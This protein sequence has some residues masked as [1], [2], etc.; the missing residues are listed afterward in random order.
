MNNFILVINAGSSSI[1]FAVYRLDDIGHRLLAEVAGQIEGIGTIKPC[2]SFNPFSGSSAVHQ[3]SKIDQIHDHSHALATLLEWLK[4][5]LAKG[6]LLG[7]GHRIV[8]GGQQFTE[9]VLIDGSVIAELEKLSPLA[10]LHQPHNLATIRALQNMMPSLPQV[11]CF[12]TAFHHSQPE[13]AQR[14]AIPLRFT[15]EGLHRYGFHGLSYEYI[16]STLPSLDPKLL[17]AKVIVAHLGSGA[18]LCALRNGNSIATT[19]GFSPLDGLVMG[20]R[21]G[22][23]DPGVLFYLADHYDMSTRDLE[24]L[25]YYESGL[26]GV[27]G[28]SSD[29]RTL[30]ASDDENANAAIALFVYRIGREIGS[31]AAAL[32]GLDALIFTGGIGENSPVIRKQVCEQAAWLGLAIDD[33]ANENGSK[34]ISLPESQVSAWQVPTDENVM[35][36][37]HTL[38]KV[39]VTK[40][41]PLNKPFKY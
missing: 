27:S 10:P 2:F 25:L 5:Y 28:I 39:T 38:R 22:S 30:L 21:C 17:E 26:L 31:L 40:K 23:I 19:M 14:I 8:H 1:K 18:S 9:P 29:M 32:G 33:N 12:D 15:E 35:I 13:V 16:V 11:A 3:A 20:T 37:Q 24:H 7:A 4:T 6:R 36:A 41:E 34:R